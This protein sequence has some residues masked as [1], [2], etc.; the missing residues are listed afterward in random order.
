MGELATSLG[1]NL[2]ATTS[3]ID[4]MVD[5][6]LVQR[7]H[8]PRDRRAVV[9]ELTQKGRETM[10]RLRGIT[11]ETITEIAARSEPD[12]MTS[13]VQGLEELRYQVDR[14]KPRTNDEDT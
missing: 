7:T 10:R 8:D 14:V 6:E 4:R 13:I 9:C 2:S 3:L 1:H 11:E 12:Q 5:K